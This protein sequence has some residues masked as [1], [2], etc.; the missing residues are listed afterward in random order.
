MQQEV[1]KQWLGGLAQW[2]G[3]STKDAGPGASSLSQQRGS[4]AG[5]AWG[6]PRGE[7]TQSRNELTCR[8][9]GTCSLPLA[10]PPHPKKILLQVRRGQGPNT[11][12]RGH[13]L[14]LVGEAFTLH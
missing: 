14:G 2:F 12:E 4:G 8:V 6:A 1:P 11:E 5:P 10:P 13:V 3:E 7:N 9:T